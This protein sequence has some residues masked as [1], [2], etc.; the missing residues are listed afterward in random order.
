VAAARRVGL[1]GIL[2]LSGK[3]TAAEAAA[4]GIELDAIVRNLTEVVRAV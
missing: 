1:R 2:V 3:T 4:S